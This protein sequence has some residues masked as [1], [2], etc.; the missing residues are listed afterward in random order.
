MTKS[1]SSRLRIAIGGFLHE[2]NT[3]APNKA[4]YEAFEH[5]GGWPHLSQGEDVIE[6]TRNVNQPIC[7]FI[8]EAEEEGWLLVPTLWC[9]AT[10][11]AHV[12]KD[13]FE[14]ISYRIVEGIRQAGP[15]DGVFLDL[16]GAMVAEHLDDG[17]GEIIERVRDVI[18]SEVPLVV[19]L[20]LHAN[21]TR[22]MFD[23]AD[24]L[25]SYRTYP[26]VDMAETGKRCADHLKHLMSEGFL[27]KAFRQIPFLIPVPWQCT[28][29][30]PARSLYDHLRSKETNGIISL[31]LN[32]GFPAADIYDC[33]PSVTVY[34]KKESDAEK[35]ADEIYERM[36][37]SESDFNGKSYGPKEG[38]FEAVRISSESGGLVVIADTQDNPGAGGSSDTTGMLRALIEANPERSAIGLLCD[39]EAAKMAHK[40][41]I[42]TKVHLSIGGKSNIDGDSPFVGEFT[43]LCLSEGNLIAA[44]PYYGGAR[45][46]LGLSACLGIGNVQLLVCTHNVQMA[47]QEMYRFLGIEPSEQAVL[48]NKSSV[49]FRADFSSIADDILVCTAPGAN[50]LN[51]ADLPFKNLRKSVR[52]SPNGPV[53]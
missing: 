48:V 22:R 23:L 52:L 19:S 35:V 49:H 5:G 9:Y 32:F 30:E 25:I 17:E 16:H 12:T 24:A 7:G 8:E 1:N 43:V 29:I 38:V 2:T 14:S 28:D 4:N 27:H 11:S 20:D 39:P 6:A 15:L 50:P 40:S 33:G 36:M 37:V 45:M 53:F 51:P 44:G 10:P 47:D 13:A 41:G 31:S 26:H 42:G 21:V 46:Q 3:F 34:A 18:G